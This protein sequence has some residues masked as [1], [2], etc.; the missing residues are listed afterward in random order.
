MILKPV[1]KVGPLEVTTIDHES[2]SINMLIHMIGSKE[3]I[4][5]SPFQTNI[6]GYVKTACLYMLNEGFI[7]GEI[8]SWLTNVGAVVHTPE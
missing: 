7:D 1:L 8:S 2:R 6:G 5:N 3:E 4:L